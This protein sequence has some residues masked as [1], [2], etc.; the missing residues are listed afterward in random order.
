MHRIVRMILAAIATSAPL[1]HAASFVA[2]TSQPGDPVGKGASAMLG[3]ESGNSWRIAVNDQN[4]VMVSRTPEYAFL[5]FGAGPQGS[6]YATLVPGTYENAERLAGRLSP[7]LDVSLPGSACNTA[8]GRFVVLEIQYNGTAVERFAAD[9]ES[10]CDGSDPAM[11]GSVR[12]NSS[13]PYTPVVPPAPALTPATI[14]VSSFA[15]DQLLH[16][17]RATLTNE[18]GQM[19]RSR[20]LYDG[21]TITYGPDSYYPEWKFTIA[22]PGPGPLQPGTYDTDVLGTVVDIRRKTGYCWRS[23]ARVVVYEVERNGVVPTKLAADIEWACNDPTVVTTYVGI[24]YNSSLPYV[25]PLSG[26]GAPTTPSAPRTVTRVNG[27][28]PTTGTA[29]ALSI[30][31]PPAACT[32]ASYSFVAPQANTRPPLPAG[33]VAPYGF[34]DFRADNCGKNAYQFFIFET[35]DPLP[36]TAQWWKYGPT[37]DNAAP[38]WYRE[39]GQASGNALHFSVVDGQ[40]DGDAVSD[41]SLSHYGAL[42][43]P[44][45]PYQDLWWSGAA[46]N[47]WG[48][49]IVQHRDVLF[50]NLFVYDAQG[51]PIWYVMPSGTWNPSRTAFTGSLYLPKGSPYNAYDASRF[52]VGP[53]VGSAT[54]TFLNFNQATFDYSINGIAGRK[55]IS[56]VAFGPL[57]SALSTSQVWEGDLWWGGVAQNGWGMALLKQYDTL[58]ALW[59]TYD[60]NGDPTW[61]VMPAITWYRDNIMQGTVYRPEGSAWLGV[62]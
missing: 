28:A 40:T 57:A 36:P 8:F 23:H 39:P 48:M 5:A 15:V 44:G 3:T 37:Y 59:Y 47:G 45:G 16:G 55:S 34:V 29:I 14:T 13:I 6:G 52:N 35:A 33:F 42:V 27:T 9:F 26:P 46:E 11:F 7:S 43:V 61:F 17:E 60:A 31:S 49:S 4:Q 25:D 12:Y 56:K 54:L 2:Y 51:K 21:V 19:R 41:G 58:F 10:H 50:A 30:N 22:P 20:T 1:V 62:L 38:H 53:A 32:I 18:Q 24:R